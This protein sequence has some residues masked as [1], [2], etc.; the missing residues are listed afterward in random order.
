MS[1][2]DGHECPTVTHVFRLGSLRRAARTFDFDCFRVVTSR[3][4]PYGRE[5]GN[6]G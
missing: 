2:S 6:D 4:P 3:L 5:A 1:K